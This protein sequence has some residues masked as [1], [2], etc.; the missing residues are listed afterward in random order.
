MPGKESIQTKSIYW[1]ILI[2]NIPAGNDKNQNF[3]IFIST[4]MFS[5]INFTNKKAPCIHC[6]YASTFEL[7]TRQVLIFQ[8]ILYVNFAL[9]LLV[10][11][12]EWRTMFVAYITNIELFPKASFGI[13]NVFACEFCTKTF[14]FGERMKNHVCCLHVSETWTIPKGK[15][16]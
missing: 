2:V 4:F 3:D 12:R 16:W 6:I 8:M 15:F 1:S 7:L 5:F 11:V 14:G 10:L 13:S 9:K